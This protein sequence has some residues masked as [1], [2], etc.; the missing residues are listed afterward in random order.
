MR[1]KG[2]IGAGALYGGISRLVHGPVARGHFT[3]VECADW[4]SAVKLS[5]MEDVLDQ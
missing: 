2:T 1:S 3:F 4:G 5:L